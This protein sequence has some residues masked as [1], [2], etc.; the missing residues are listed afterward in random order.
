MFVNPLLGHALQQH[1]NAHL[2]RPQN[3]WSPHH[4]GASSAPL[5]SPGVSDADSA[6][7]LERRRG[8]GR[9]VAHERLDTSPQQPRD[10]RVD[11]PGA[12]VLSE[13]VKL[14]AEMVMLLPYFYFLKMMQAHVEFCEDLYGRN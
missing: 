13:L 9:A 1:L 12:S 6:G 4:L 5:E 3:Q 8:G 14:Q 7:L 11:A 2:E 10:V